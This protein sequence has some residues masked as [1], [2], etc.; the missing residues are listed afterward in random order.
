MFA[1]LTPLVG[2]TLAVLI[3]GEPLSSSHILGSVLILGGVWIA[4]RPTAPAPVAGT[5]THQQRL[6]TLVPSKT[7]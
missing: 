3:L 1:N 4:A 2:V 5:P 6:P 7:V